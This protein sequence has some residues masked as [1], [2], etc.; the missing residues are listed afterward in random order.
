MDRKSVQPEM[1]P[2]S[3]NVTARTGLLVVA[4]LVICSVLLLCNYLL[5][6]QRIAALEERL[7]TLQRS[8]QPN[9]KHKLY[10]R[11][12]RSVNL[13]DLERRLMQSLDER[14]LVLYSI[15]A[16]SVLQTSLQTLC[17]ELLK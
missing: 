6:N 17:D 11:E 3:A 7:E 2:A 1:N 9:P 10:A 14:Y 16:L 5:V 4:V 15:L 13:A 8:E 12:K